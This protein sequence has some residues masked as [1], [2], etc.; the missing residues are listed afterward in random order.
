M[1]LTASILS[2][3]VLVQLVHIMHTVRQ[4]ATVTTWLELQEALVT[5]STVLEEQVLITQLLEVMILL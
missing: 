4:Q 5:L 3:E 1:A 2:T